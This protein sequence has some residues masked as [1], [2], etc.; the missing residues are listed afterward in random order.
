[1]P[2]TTYPID[3]GKMVSSDARVH[4]RLEGSWNKKV[5]QINSDGEIPLEIDAYYDNVYHYTVEQLRFDMELHCNQCHLTPYAE[6]HGIDDSYIL[7]LSAERFRAE[8]TPEG[9]PE[10]P[11]LPKWCLIG[12]KDAI[13]ETQ[14]GNWGLRPEPMPM[15]A[16]ATDNDFTV[17]SS[18]FYPNNCHGTNA[19]GDFFGV[20]SDALNALG[21]Y[22]GNQ[23]GLQN[24]RASDDGTWNMNIDITWKTELPVFDT[25]AHLLAYIRS[26][27]R[28]T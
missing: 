24:Y 25:D 20:S 9:T 3:L 19:D 17:N 26:G 2:T 4:F 21:S 7:G 27:G 1:M 10:H 18:Y 15:G 13:Y 8:L 23:L 12:D 5:Y 11:I 6:E 22:L 16:Q 14:D 28:I